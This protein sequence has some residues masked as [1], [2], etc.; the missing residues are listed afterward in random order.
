VSQKPETVFDIEQLFTQ[1]N[2]SFTDAAL[3]LRKTFEESPDWKDSPFVYHMP[4]MHLSMR[5]V[6][7][8]SDGTVKGFF[9]KDST[10]N[11]QELASTV[12]IDVVA[13]PRSVVPRSEP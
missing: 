4:K 13:V 8:H 2:T 9:N 1:L 10:E 11:Q 6:L 7:S 12:E 5:L 3:A